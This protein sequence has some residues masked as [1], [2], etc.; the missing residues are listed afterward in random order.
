MDQLG[1]NNSHILRQMA[2]QQQQAQAAAQAAQVQAHV[3]QTPVM[4]TL[5]QQQQQLAQQNQLLLATAK[6]H[7][8]FALVHRVESCLGFDGKASSPVRNP[9]P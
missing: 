5:T 9:N 8:S 2:V 4:Q 1:L 3:S 7:V 6:A